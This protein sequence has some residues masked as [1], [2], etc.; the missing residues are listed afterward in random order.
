[1]DTKEVKDIAELEVRRYFDHFLKDVYPNLMSEHLNSCKY[2][3]MLNKF[4]WVTV[5]ILIT[6]AMLAPAVGAE[7]LSLM[8]KIVVG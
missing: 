1:M 2:G 6:I 4:K 3:K 8:K 7:L 5:G